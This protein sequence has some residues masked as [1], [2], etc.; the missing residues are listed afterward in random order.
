MPIYEYECEKCGSVME[1]T[2]KISDPHPTECADC[3][4]GPL[5]K[6]ISRSAFRLAG[7]GWYSDAYDSKDQLKKK[8]SAS[9][10]GKTG[11]S[12]KGGTEKKQ[13]SDKSDSSSP[14]VA[15]TKT[16]KSPSKSSSKSSDK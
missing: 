10:S 6:L 1:V 4:G 11:D 13:A 8:E 9:E 14:K 7:G 12:E 2:M 15:S 3:G 16:E 5:Q